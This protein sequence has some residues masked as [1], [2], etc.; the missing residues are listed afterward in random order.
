MLSELD[1]NKD[2]RA[3]FHIHTNHSPDSRLNPRS[4]VKLCERRNINLIAITDHNTINGALETRDLASFEVIIGE[5]ILSSDGEIIGLYLEKPI[6]KH[7]SA[8]ETI[9]QIKDQ[10]GIVQIPHPFDRF[11]SNHIDIKSLI[12][13]LPDVDIFEV[14]NARTTL[15]QDIR[16]SVQFFQKH[17]EQH[18]LRRIG[19][20]DTHNSYE[21]GKTYNILPSFNDQTQ[22]LDALNHNEIIGKK[23]TPFIHFETRYSVLHKKIIKKIK[24]N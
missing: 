14:F 17:Q 21:I 1:T 15:N 19:V 5:E 16:K 24:P 13:I 18:N 2:I 3:D 9:N 23:T 20:T 12:E 7:L 6:T 10:G 4:L 8:R 11:R 22:L